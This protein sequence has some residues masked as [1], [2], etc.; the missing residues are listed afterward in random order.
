[1][2]TIRNVKLTTVNRILVLSVLA[3]AGAIALAWQ[4]QPARAF[5]DPATGQNCAT[6]GTASHK[7][8]T[9]TPVPTPRPSATATLTASPTATWTATSTA[10]PTATST[11]TPTSAPP[12]AAAPVAPPP[13]TACTQCGPSWPLISGG[14]LLLIAL[15]GLLFYLLF[16]RPLSLGS[17]N[18]N[19]FPDG[20]QNNTVNV[21][22][23]GLESGTIVIHDGE[24]GG[25]GGLENFTV[26][27]RPDGLG[28]ATIDFQDPGGFENTIGGKDIGDLSGGG[29]S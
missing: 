24:F 9:R 27:W 28:N 13:T 16:R 5:C 7:R 18:P 2:K 20:R 6:P 11:E 17:T 29:M 25:D 14:I 8:A 10:S 22:D 26:N 4:V 21:P 19:F 23:G 15:G 12:Q 3:M 1:M